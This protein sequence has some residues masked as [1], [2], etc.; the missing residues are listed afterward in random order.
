MKR[1]VT[2]PFGR[3]AEKYVMSQ[4][5]AKEEDHDLLVEWADRQNLAG[6]SNRCGHTAKAIAR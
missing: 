4:T 2:D 6:Y 5:Y 3:N 1:K